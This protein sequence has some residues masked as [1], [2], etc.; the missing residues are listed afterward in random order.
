[1]ISVAATACS[2]S[3]ASRCPC[4]CCTC[5]NET[6]IKPILIKMISPS[7]SI[8]RSR[9]VVVRIR[10]SGHWPIQSCTY[11]LTWSGVVRV[12]YCVRRVASAAAAWRHVWCTRAYLRLAA[13][14]AT[15]SRSRAAAPAVSLPMPSRGPSCVRCSTRFH[16]VHVFT[17]TWIRHIAKDYVLQIDCDF[18]VL[19]FGRIL[20]KSFEFDA[21][22]GTHVVVQNLLKIFANFIF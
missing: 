15:A 10:G 6:C 9:R 20:L 8:R 22:S 13:A 4:C 11:R 5:T 2:S 14:V 21:L 12:C 19:N 18:Y 16:H 17:Y 1:M 7:F 3:S